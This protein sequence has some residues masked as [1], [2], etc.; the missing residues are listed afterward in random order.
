M[1]LITAAAILVFGCAL[2]AL[3][4]VADEAASPSQL[5]LDAGV[6]EF[7]PTR[8][9]LTVG[10][11]WFTMLTPDNDWTL[12]FDPSQKDNYK[13]QGTLKVLDLKEVGKNRFEFPGV[14]LERHGEKNGAVCVSI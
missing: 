7:Q 8:P 11:A 1:K 14:T 6:L 4:A 5:K 2:P 9:D 10:I 12:I 3:A 13:D